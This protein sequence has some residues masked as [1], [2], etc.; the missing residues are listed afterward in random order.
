MGGVYRPAASAGRRPGLP[1][2]LTMVVLALVLASVSAAACSTGDDSSTLDAAIPPAAAQAAD[3]SDDA[4]PAVPVRPEVI[5]PASWPSAIDEVYG[6]YWLYWDAFAAAHAPPETDVDFEPLRLLSTDANWASLS[7]ELEQFAASGHVLV[8]PAD[9]ITEHLVRVPNV[10]VL[11][12]DE[13]AELILQDC[14]IDD[15]VQQTVDGELVDEVR[16]AKLMNVVMKVVDGQ[17]RVDAVTRATTD[18]DGYEQ[19]AELLPQ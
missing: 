15:F 7:D 13:G 6:R 10:E 3:S 11:T 16:E 19:C 5:I 9:S 18:S 4:Q 12:K 1:P 8:L 14:W 17:W 2:S